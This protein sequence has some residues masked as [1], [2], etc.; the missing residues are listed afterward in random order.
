MDAI[1]LLSVILV[2]D[3]ILVLNFNLLS[4]FTMGLC[5]P[6]DGCTNVVF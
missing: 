6:P 4:Y 1:I 2:D 5:H 3:M